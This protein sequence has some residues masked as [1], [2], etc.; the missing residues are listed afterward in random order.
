MHAIALYAV[1]AGAV[2]FIDSGADAGFFQTLRQ[3]EAT[4]SAAN[5]DD[6]ERCPGRVANGT[7]I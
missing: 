5:D 3:R 4:N 1:G 6:V 2:A 7:A